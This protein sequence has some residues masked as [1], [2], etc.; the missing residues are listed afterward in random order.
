MIRA[1]GMIENGLKLSRTMKS[2]RFY[3]TCK[4]TSWSK[5]VMRSCIRDKGPKSPRYSQPH[6]H[7]CFSY[8]PSAMG[9]IQKGQEDPAHTVGLH[10][11]W[12]IL[13]LWNPNLLQ[14]ALSKPVWSLLQRKRLF[15]LY[16]TVSKPASLKRSSR[17]K[18]QSVFLLTGYLKT[19]ETYGELYPCKWR[20]EWPTEWVHRKPRIQRWRNITE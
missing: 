5:E 9:V 6:K 15:L 4:L 3:L 10:Y 12:G 19:Q 18:K 17:T 7:F 2:L 14:W 16:W 20:I 1:L 11:S 13:N 8:P